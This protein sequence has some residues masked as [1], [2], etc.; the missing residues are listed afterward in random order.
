MGVCLGSGRGTGGGVEVR[1]EP[2]LCSFEFRASSWLF[3]CLLKG[4]HAHEVAV[5]TSLCG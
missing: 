3:L 4:R 5:L 2:K 1:G